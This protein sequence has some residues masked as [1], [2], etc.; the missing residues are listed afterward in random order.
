[1]R[2]RN[3]GQA[4]VEFALVSPVL[5]SFLFA[6]MQFGYAF[7]TYNNL[8]KAVRDGCRYASTRTYAGEAAYSSDVRNVVVYGQPNPP[9]G[10]NPLVHGLTTAAVSVTPPTGMMT[11]VR[12]KISTFTMPLPISSV[13]LTNKPNVS[14]R[15]VGRYV[16]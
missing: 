13:T 12:V 9:A 15:F 16:P 11:T 5:I 3:R 7:Y 4:L 8:E 2:R 14:F 10:A 6:T 1:M